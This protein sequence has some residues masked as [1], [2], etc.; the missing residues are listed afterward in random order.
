[1]GKKANMDNFHWVG[2]KVHH[3]P[4]AA[5]VRSV[6]SGGLAYIN[7]SSFDNSS[8]VALKFLFV[9]TFSISVTS[10]CL[11]SLIVKRSKKYFIAEDW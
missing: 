2:E 9:L 1:M 7:N 10:S 11:T 8:F 3:Q 4:L 5:A 6:F